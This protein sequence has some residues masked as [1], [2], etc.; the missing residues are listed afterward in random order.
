MEEL[1]REVAAILAEAPGRE[2]DMKS[3]I[4]P[5]TGFEWL[6]VD[7]LGADVHYCRE[8]RTFKMTMKTYIEKMIKRFKL[9]IGKPVHSPNF[10]EASFDT[11]AAVMAKDYPLREVVGALQWVT[12]AARPDAALPVNAL[13]RYVAKPCTRA[14]ARACN[15]VMKYLR[16]TKAEG[17]G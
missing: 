16:T 11:V 1:R 13:A 15:K 7:F 14:I 8:G 9:T 6:E 5:V 4:D 12:T 2:I 10:S 17:I 3:I